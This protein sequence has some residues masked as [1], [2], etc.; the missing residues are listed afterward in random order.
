MAY[1]NNKVTQRKIAEEGAIYYLVQL[2][3]DPPT[4]E[5]QVEVAIALGCIVLSNPSNQE[6]LQEEKDFK[7]DVLL[8]LLRSEDEVFSDLLL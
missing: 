5:V 2:L 4:E 3:N 8:D 7:F 6:K 1:T